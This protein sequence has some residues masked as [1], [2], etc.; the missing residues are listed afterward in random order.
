[1]WS[2]SRTHL[3]AS[4]RACVRSRGNNGPV[5]TSCLRTLV[6]P[7]PMRH[8]STL[9]TVILITTTK[10]QSI[11][12]PD[13][14]TACVFDLAGW[15]QFC[16]T[17]DAFSAEGHGSCYA[18]MLPATMPPDPCVA[19]N[20]AIGVHTL[21]SGFLPN[22]PYV[23]SIWTLMS[24]TDLTSDI[25]IF[26]VPAGTPPYFTTGYYFQTWPVGFIDPPE[27]WMQQNINFT[28]PPITAGLDLYFFIEYSIAPDMVP[29]TKLFDEISFTDLS[30]GMA[31]ATERAPSLRF[32]PVTDQL[33]LT[34]AHPPR[35]FQAIDVTGRRVPLNGQQQTA[36]AVVM[37]AQH[38]P[39]GVHLLWWN[40]ADGAHSARFVKD[41]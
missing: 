8:L 16:T 3:F 29:G 27:Q 34:L 28:L 5:D 21:M 25:G 1:M 19:N 20:E 39:P 40:T 15:D 18:L 7:S 26:G 12:N 33:T 13:F 14:E 24:S 31:P 32:D 10:A 11:P 2:L 17:P 35:S 4:T 22:V 30:T 6:M 36:N 41:R 23:L 9:L 38:L 37:N